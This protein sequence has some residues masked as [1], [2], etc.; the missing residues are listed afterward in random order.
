MRVLICICLL[1]L[2]LATINVHDKMYVQLDATKPC[3][4]RLNGSQ[5]FGCTSSRGGNV[6]VIHLAYNHTELDWVLSSGKADSYVVGLPLELFT[7]SNLEKLNS[8]DRVAGVLVMQNVTRKKINQFSTE[9]KCPNR[10]SGLAG[11]PYREPVCTDAEPW[12]TVGSAIAMRRWDMPIFFTDNN[13]VIDQV[14]ECFTHFNLP[15]DT[16]INR[17]LCALEMSSHMFASIDSKTCLRRSS[18]LYN[19]NPLKYCDQ[20][21]GLNIYGPVIPF[22][23]FKKPANE[24]YVIVS[25]RLDS[26]SLFYG[27]AP[28]ALSTSTSLVSLLLTAHLLFGLINDA[29]KDGKKNKNVKKNVLFMLFNGEA[30]DYI[31]SGRTVYDMKKGQFPNKEEAIKLEDVALFVELSQ[32]KNTEPITIHTHDDTSDKNPLVRGFI[33]NFKNNAKNYGVNATFPEDKAK[34]FPPSSYQSFLAQKNDFPGLVFSSYRTDFTNLFYH[35]IYDDS[36]NLEY[37]YSNHTKI[38]GDSIQGVIADFS[39]VLAYTLFE[40]MT[41]SPAPGERNVTYEWA[42]Q[43]MHCFVETINCEFYA[44]LFSEPFSPR[45]AAPLDYYVGVVNQRPKHVL[46]LARISL[47]YLM[48]KNVSA[49]GPDEC[50]KS[51][52]TTYWIPPKKQC[53]ESAV[54]TSEAVS[55][56]FSIPD[57]K[58]EDGLYSSWTESSWTMTNVRMF[59]KPSPKYEWLVFTTGTSV[60]VTSF[61]IVFWINR[62]ARELFNY[63]HLITASN[64]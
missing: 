57:Y 10:Y 4:R 41:G 14:E 47:T 12:N 33:D 54:N 18:S 61:V 21:G 1:E 19:V 63:P 62:N 22:D 13:D 6:G 53:I 58:F 24:S 44:G 64:I 27:R 48:S 26:T 37:K 49:S 20:L 35:S 42:D 3:I 43:L 46:D 15:L 17:S 31:G 23:E 55:P 45:D 34:H 30:Y 9:D 16:Q 5:S 7:L 40:L 25:A 28:G 36:V 2:S 50:T 59:L 39:T 8:S 11:P 29:K 52:T 51:N 56:A 38:A 32:L 60:M